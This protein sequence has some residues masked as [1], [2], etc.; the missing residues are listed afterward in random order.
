MARV[1]YTE[2]METNSID[3]LDKF[4]VIDTVQDGYFNIY[5]GLHPY[6]VIGDGEDLA[7]YP[8]YWSKDNKL[9]NEP[10]PIIRTVGEDVFFTKRTR[11]DPYNGPMLDEVQSTSDTIE[12]KV[13]DAFN[14][15]ASDEF[16][17]GHPNPIHVFIGDE[18]E[19]GIEDEPVEFEFR[20]IKGDVVEQKPEEPGDP[21]E[22]DNTG[23]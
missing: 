22:G 16:T 10:Y 4:L 23:E 8:L 2:A 7:V 12:H 20:N 1:T 6:R 13:L 9:T 3:I 21:T 5:K 19:V 15:F 11:N 17:L 14:V 18:A